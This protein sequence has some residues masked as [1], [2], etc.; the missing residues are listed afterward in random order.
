[1]A[2]TVNGYIQ[3]DPA[4][5][6]FSLSP[7]QAMV[8]A[9][10]DSPVYLEGAFELAAAMIEASQRSSKASE[11]E[12]GLPGAKAQDASSVRWVRSFDPATSTALSRLGFLPSMA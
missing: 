6:Q 10:K 5:E 7:E 8:F 4:T 1:M 3:F 12:R 11:P 9:I 2:Q